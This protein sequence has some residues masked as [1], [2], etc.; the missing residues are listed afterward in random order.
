MKISKVLALLSSIVMSLGSQMSHAGSAG[1]VGGAT[2]MTQIWNNGELVKAGID[3]AQT[4]ATTVSSYITQ[5]EQYRNQLLNTI[6]LDP[7]IVGEEVRKIANTYQEVS[8]YQNRLTSLKGSLEYQKYIWDDRVSRARSGN[9]R[10]SDYMA[11]EKQK[12]DQGNA[13]AK[14]RLDES[15]RVFDQTKRDIEEINQSRARLPNALGVNES[16]QELHGVMSKIA[17]QNTTITGLLDSKLTMDSERDQNQAEKKG[18]SESL[19]NNQLRVN[20]EISDRQ[21]EFGRKGWRDY[22]R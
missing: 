14:A 22:E 1:G 18:V 11:L 15:K 10:L 13:L 12:A 5:L 2:E 16:V 3:Q 7:S 4:A 9:L 6:G 21:K 20:K 17:I 8:N 19:I